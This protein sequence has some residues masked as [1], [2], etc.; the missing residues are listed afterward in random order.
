MHL[1][2]PS[3]LLFGPQWNAD[4]GSLVKMRDI[5]IIIIHIGL[6][7]HRLCHTFSTCPKH[8]N[9]LWST[10]LSKIVFELQY[11][12]FLRSKLICITKS[13]EHV[14]TKNFKSQVQTSTSC[15]SFCQYSAKEVTNAAGERT[16]YAG[17]G[18]VPSTA[19]ISDTN[20]YCTT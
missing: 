1:K 20:H 4:S 19:Q 13:Q 18:C 15:T 11:L 17:H 8:H 5:N 10:L 9:T 2:H 7:H 14:Y 6:A 12:W 3:D 16:H